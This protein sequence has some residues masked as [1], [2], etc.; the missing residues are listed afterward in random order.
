MRY[1]THIIGDF[2]ET[3]VDIYISNAQALEFLRTHGL[4][5]AALHNRRSSMPKIMLKLH[6]VAH[7]TGI[8]GNTRKEYAEGTR[9]NR[10]YYCLS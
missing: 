4:C 1:L 2:Q 3:Y 5:V 10:T 6:S 9:P 8:Q 7:L